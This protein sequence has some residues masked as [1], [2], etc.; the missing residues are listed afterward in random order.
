[1][2][3]NREDLVL[4]SVSLYLHVHLRLRPCFAIKVA[5]GRGPVSQQKSW[6]SCK[7]RLV[8]T[9]FLPAKN[10]LLRVP[11]VAISR[12]TA[13]GSGG[14]SRRCPSS[15]CRRLNGQLKLALTIKPPDKPHNTVLQ[16]GQ[17]Q[18]RTRRPS[19]SRPFLGRIE[20]E[21]IIRLASPLS[22]SIFPL[23][24]PTYVLKTAAAMSDAHS[25]SRPSTVNSRG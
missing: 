18:S 2:D 12:Q 4:V 20:N 21:M 16:S 22:F 1:M 17:S 7:Q 9:P 10:S 13:A 23:Q 3:S 24:Y 15:C 6:D 8:G 25:C 19:G 5:Y 11:P 14:G